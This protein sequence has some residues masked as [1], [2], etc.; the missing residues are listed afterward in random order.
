MIIILILIIDSAKLLLLS[1]IL[2]IQF[3]KTGYFSYF[4]NSRRFFGSADLTCNKVKCQTPTVIITISV[5]K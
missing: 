1:H 5:G 2:M 4:D 3:I